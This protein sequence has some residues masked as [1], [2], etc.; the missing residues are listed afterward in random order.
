MIRFIAIIVL[1]F[2][3][4]AF[5]PLLIDEKG[6]ILISIADHI[7][8]LTIYTAIFWL[9]TITVAGMLLYKVTKKGFKFSFKLWD[10]VV[11]A[12]KRKGIAT[13]NKGLGSY[14]LGDYENAEK[15]FSKS[16]KPSQRPQSAYLLAACAS[17]NQNLDEKT[18]QYL[19]LLDVESDKFDKGDLTGLL[20]KIKLLMDQNSDESNQKARAIIDENHRQI[21]HEY[22]LLS[23]EI[24][25][26]IAE[27]R[28][29]AAIENLPAARKHKKI[30]EETVNLWEKE[31]FYGM[32]NDK[33]IRYDQN[34][35]TSYF[36]GLG[37]KIK[38][39]E[40]ILFAYCKTLAEHN[41]NK[42][43]VD[44]ILPLLKKQPSKSFFELLRT[45]PIKQGDALIS[46]VQKHL[47]KDSKNTQ[48][49]SCL[50]HLALMSEQW[51]LAEKSFRSLLKL[52][53]KGNELP[54]SKYDIQGLAC[55]LSEQSQHQ[56]ANE[57]WL[58]YSNM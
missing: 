10:S 38:S 24:L 25:L 8:E 15:L 22:R 17:A 13:F 16:A 57:M 46:V 21:G 58:K 18:N 26:C 20:V 41:I 37:R 40:T 52:E 4:L 29:E 54:Y 50:G 42:P 11:F 49:L 36:E 39:R 1:F 9:A 31:A 28:F 55:A 14:L 3:V 35:L 27:R 44:L 5:S 34:A 43:L 32:F 12:S 19:D 30:N 6:Y 51:V 45:L 2:A 7:Y 33:I 23:L 53:V 47:Q 48:W 56:L